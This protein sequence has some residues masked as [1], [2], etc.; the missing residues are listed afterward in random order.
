MQVKFAYAASGMTRGGEASIGD[1]TWVVAASICETATIVAVGSTLRSASCTAPLGRNNQNNE[2][3]ASRSNRHARLARPRRIAVSGAT[4]SAILPTRNG[5]ARP[6]AY[7]FGGTFSASVWPAAQAALEIGATILA[8]G[9]RA[10]KVASSALDAQRRRAGWKAAFMP[11]IRRPDADFAQHGEACARTLA[12]VAAPLAF[13]AACVAPGAKMC[14]DWFETSRTPEAMSAARASARQ[15]PI[16]GGVDG[17]SREGAI[18]LH[19]FKDGVRAV[20]DV[21][22]V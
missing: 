9:V 17:G 3:A 14:A 2:Q 20:L 8:G 10:R 12:P 16:A 19:D 21:V 15:V 5:R 22:K 6:G 13:D 11:V 1:A 7:R 4:A 18:T